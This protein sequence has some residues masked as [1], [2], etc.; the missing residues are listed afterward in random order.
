MPENQGKKDYQVPGRLSL[1]DLK[2]EEEE[3]KQA[4][5]LMHKKGSPKL[6]NAMSMLTVG[7]DFALTIAIPLII[8][9]Y[10]GKKLDGKFGTNYIV[11]IGLILAIIVS[12]ISIS[13]QI[14]KLS[15]LV[16]K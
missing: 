6:L 4:Q 13:K 8:A 3:L 12:S 1:E 2:R 14:K 16:K 15:K 9:V 11:I 5:D 10:F 7:I